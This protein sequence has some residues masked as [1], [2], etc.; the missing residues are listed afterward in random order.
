MIRAEPAWEK[1]HNHSIQKFDDFDNN[2][3]IRAEPAWATT[4]LLFADKNTIP[5]CSSKSD[6]GIN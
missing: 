4:T 2:D 6:L 3:L 5:V 1:A